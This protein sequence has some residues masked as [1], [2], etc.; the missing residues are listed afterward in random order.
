MYILNAVAAADRKLL[1][2]VIGI[3]KVTVN[4][5]EIAAKLSQDFGITLT[6]KA[7]K[8]RIYRLKKTADGR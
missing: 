8:N 3:A 5:E 6:A 7:I 2:A 4:D 1:L